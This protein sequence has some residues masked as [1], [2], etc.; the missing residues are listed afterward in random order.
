MQQVRGKTLNATGFARRPSCKLALTPHKRSATENVMA[1]DQII[2]LSSQEYL[3]FERQ[4]Q[5]KHEYIDGDV[6]EMVGA[7]RPHILI[8][9]NIFYA[10]QSQIRSRPFEVYQSDMRVRI[11]QGPYYYPDVTV[12]PSPP[13]LEDKEADTLLNPLVI[14]EIL[15]PSTR[16][17]DR[18]E[19]LDNYRRI[20][21]LTDYLIVAQDRLWIDRY[22]RDGNEWRLE[23]F[24]KADDVLRLPTPGCELSLA[25]VYERIFLPK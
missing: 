10:V 8:A 4:S 20:P 1:T 11:P 12:A 17:I 16:R 21:S 24:S 6:R 2:G 25:D 9:G 18:G 14:V 23:D 15:S 19:K 22:V 3:A 7:S 5:R 13:E